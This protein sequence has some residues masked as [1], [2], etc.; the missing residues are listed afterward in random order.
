MKKHGIP[1]D[2]SQIK[3]GNLEE[4]VDQLSDL[5]VEIDQKQD[6]VRVRVFCE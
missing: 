6:N 1:F 5:T 2:L 4:L 3:P